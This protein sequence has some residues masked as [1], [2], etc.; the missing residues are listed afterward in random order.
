[1]M[2]GVNYKKCKNSF[3]FWKVDVQSREYTKKMLENELNFI[4]VD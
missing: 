4:E 3:F 1:M 2:D